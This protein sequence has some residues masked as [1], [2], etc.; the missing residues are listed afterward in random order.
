MLKLVLAN[1]LGVIL[2]QKVIR[3]NSVDLFL[4]LVL[5][6]DDGLVLVGYVFNVGVHFNFDGSNTVVACVGHI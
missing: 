4:S 1:Q 6:W 2:Q 5:C 3:L